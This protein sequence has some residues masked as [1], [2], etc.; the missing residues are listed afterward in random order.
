MHIIASVE[1]GGSGALQCSQ[2]GLSSSMAVCCCVRDKRTEFTPNP[3]PVPE[4][5]VIFPKAHHVQGDAA[6]GRTGKLQRGI[7][8]QTFDH[9][10]RQE[11]DGFQHQDRK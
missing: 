5:T 9:R 7:G 11:A 8:A 4:E 10:S 2:V 1:L 6:R 3:L